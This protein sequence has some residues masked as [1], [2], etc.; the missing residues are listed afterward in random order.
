MHTKAVYVYVTAF[1]KV[2]V[3]SRLYYLTV[4]DTCKHLNVTLNI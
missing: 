1:Q 2:P 4:L 3:K